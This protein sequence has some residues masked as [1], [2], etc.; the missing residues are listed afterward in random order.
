MLSERARFAVDKMFQ[1]GCW[2]CI[3]P[4]S[5]DRKKFRLGYPHKTH[6]VIYHIRRYIVLSMWCFQVFRLVQSLED[7]NISSRIRVMNIVWSAAYGLLNLCYL[8][9]QTR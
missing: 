9:F 5:W 6:L 4:Y 7:D 2:M 1:W 3:Y 8:Q